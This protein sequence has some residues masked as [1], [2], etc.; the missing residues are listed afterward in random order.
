MIILPIVLWIYFT[1]QFTLSWKL[2]LA[3]ALTFI[4]HGLHILWSFAELFPEPFHCCECHRPGFGWSFRR[5]DS[6]LFK[7]ILR[8][9]HGRRESSS[10]WDTAE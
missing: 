9:N 8:Q 5:N 1:R 4:A 2:V 7:F 6:F 3:G 10:V